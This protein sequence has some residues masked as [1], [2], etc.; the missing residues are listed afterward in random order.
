[1]DADPSVVQA[2]VAAATQ[3]TT[4][5][6]EA[7]K[8][9]LAGLHLSEVAQQAQTA[10]GALAHV[11]SHVVELRMQ[12]LEARL[13]LLDDVEGLLEA[14]RVAL[15]LERRDLYTARCRHWFGGP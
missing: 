10:Q 2:V 12:K 7:Q 13:A 4:S 5:L 8:A 11:V 3:H 15:E 6:P 1:M 14:E 9:A